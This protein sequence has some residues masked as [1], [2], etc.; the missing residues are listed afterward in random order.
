[1][2][3][4]NLTLWLFLLF[5]RFPWLCPFNC[6]V[7]LTLTFYL[8]GFSVS[9][10][11]LGPCKFDRFFPPIG[12][13]LTYSVLLLGQVR[14][15]LSSYGARF[16]WLCPSIGPGSMILPSYWPRSTDSVPPMGQVFF[17]L[18]SYLVRFF[19][20]GPGSTYSV[21]LLGQ[22]RLALFPHWAKFFWLYFVLLGMVFLAPS[23]HW[24]RFKC[25]MF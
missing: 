24:V 17:T 5:A 14:L 7:S 8:P 20:L 22:V 23:S 9:V 4:R 16:L 13:G 25:R 3:D 11:L 2:P 10:F 18:S 15:T 6:Q 21:L 12:P 19:S 1:M